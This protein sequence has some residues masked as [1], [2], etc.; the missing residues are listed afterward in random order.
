M[1]KNFFYRD[2]GN[3]RMSTEP[4]EQSIQIQHVFEHWRVRMGKP[5]ARLDQKR[6]SKIRQRLC[7]GY[8]VQDLIDAIEG[9]AISPFHNGAEQR[10]QN[11]RYSATAVY[12]D[13]ELICRDAKHV[14]Q[15]IS[16]IERDTKRRAQDAARERERKAYEDRKLAELRQAGRGHL[17]VAS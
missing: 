4:T 10:H 1:L 15:F 2:E 11:E 14:D 7:D 16:L 17:R 6:R 12:D 9:C 5:R 3:R 8:S 13:I